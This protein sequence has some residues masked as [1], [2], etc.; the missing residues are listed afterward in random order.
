MCRRWVSSEIIR[1]TI[2]VVESILFG[3]FTC[4]MG[5]DQVGRA[6][7]NARQRRERNLI[8]SGHGPGDVYVRADAFML[9]PH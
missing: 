4:I 7:N 8:V 3:I 2:L 1:S 5:G 9:L 6:D